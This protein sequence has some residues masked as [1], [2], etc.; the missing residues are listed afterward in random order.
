[1]GYNIWSTVQLQIVVREYSLILAE[2]MDIDEPLKC[3]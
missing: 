3:K 1:M 2:F